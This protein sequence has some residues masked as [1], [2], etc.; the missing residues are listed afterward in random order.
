M[1]NTSLHLDEKCHSQPRIAALLT[2]GDNIMP[3]AWHM[4]VSKSP[5]RYAVAVRSENHTHTLIKE[6]KE[7]AL[8]FLDIAYQ[9][10]YQVCGEVHGKDV[11]KFELSGLHKKG[12]SS[13]ESTLIEE[14]YMIYECTLIDII[15]YGDHD[16]FIADVNL[17]L[18]KETKE[19][20]PTLFMGKGY[21]DTVTGEPIRLQR[22][23]NV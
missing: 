13:I 18:N 20:E 3:L 16:I 1:F 14:A 2:C 6:N 23:T 11:D 9:H 7:F 8:N 21:Y 17:I 12:A 22:S 4:P 15:N 19:V 10:A 5:F